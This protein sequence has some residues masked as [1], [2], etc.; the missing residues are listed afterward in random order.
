A[1]VAGWI[2]EVP[3]EVRSGVVRAESPDVP[4]W[5]LLEHRRRAAADLVDV[6][7]LPRSVMQETDRCLQDEHVVM[8]RGAAHERADILDRVAELEA[9]D[10]EVER[11]HDG[12]VCRPA[13]HTDERQL[14]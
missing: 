1:E 8:I 10:V 4:L 11:S 3:E 14:I 5:M 7:D 2:L 12:H 9:E 6:V 13:Q